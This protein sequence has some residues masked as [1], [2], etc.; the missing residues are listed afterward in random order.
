[1]A[2][3]RKDTISQ[4][5][6]EWAKHLRRWEK[7][8]V[9]KSERRAAKAHIHKETVVDDPHIMDIDSCRQW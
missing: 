7:Q 8:Q 5:P 6:V 1:M 2:H 4:K 3:K 9:T